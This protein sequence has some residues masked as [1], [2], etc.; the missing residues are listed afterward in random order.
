MMTSCC[1]CLR[2]LRRICTL[3]LSKRKVKG[4]SFG[5]IQ[6]KIKG[7]S[8]A[9]RHRRGPVPPCRR[10]NVVDHLVNPSGVKS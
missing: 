8:L 5:L 3:N 4:Q 9:G 7:K 10:A 6:M 1:V 2:Q